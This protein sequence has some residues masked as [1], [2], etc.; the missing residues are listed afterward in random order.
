MSFTNKTANYDLPQ[1]IATDKPSYLV[2]A[3][4]AYLAIDTAMKANETAAA[5]AQSTADTNTAAISTLN[6]Q[7][8]GENGL[9]ADLTAVETLAG[10]TAGAVQT[11]NQVIGSGEPTTTAKT[12]IG[13]IN[14]LD[15]GKVA[16]GDALKFVEVHKIRSYGNGAKTLSQVLNDVFDNFKTYVAGLSDNVLINVIGIISS[17]LDAGLSHFDKMYSKSDVT[18]L[19]DIAFSNTSMSASSCRIGNIVLNANNSTARFCDLDANGVV[20]S[21][22]GST[23]YSSSQLAEI[24]FEIYTE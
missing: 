11:I 16:K 10:T 20:M 4:G 14:E 17:T 23:V 7:I 2:D 5:T 15:A 8:N 13:A 6:T 9:A 1:Y 21:D 19:T 24:H 12:L 22:I 3:N 18:S